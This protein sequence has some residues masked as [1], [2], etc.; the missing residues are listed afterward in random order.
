VGAAA[1]GAE[2]RGGGGGGGAR[3]IRVQRVANLGIIAVVIAGCRENGRTC[4][5]TCRTFWMC[6]SLINVATYQQAYFQ[7]DQ[8]LEVLQ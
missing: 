7:N 2:G 3:A 6:S 8:C 4:T 5:L 1:R